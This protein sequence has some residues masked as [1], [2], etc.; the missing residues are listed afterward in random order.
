MKILLTGAAGFIGAAVALRLLERGDSVFALDNLNDYYDVG[1]KEARL[2]RLRRHAGLVFQ[3][4]DVADREAM[5]DFLAARY[6]A[7]V[8]LPPG[9]VRYPGEN[10]FAYIDPPGRFRNVP[11]SAAHGAATSY[12]R[13]RAGDGDN[14]RLP[15]PSTQC[16]SSPSLYA[17]PRGERV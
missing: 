9:G 13:R 5:P 10:P 16:R 6:E 2:A 4:T 15:F 3:K 8:T 11:K 1:L 12:T 14:T 17:P 7:V